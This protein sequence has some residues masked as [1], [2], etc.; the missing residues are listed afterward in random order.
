MYH[1]H[2]QLEGKVNELSREKGDLESRVEEDQDEIDELLEKQRSHIVQTSSHQTQ[3]T[4][5]NLQIEELEENNHNLESK[6]CL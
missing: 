1:L 6:V 5:A 2:I 4:E 3:M